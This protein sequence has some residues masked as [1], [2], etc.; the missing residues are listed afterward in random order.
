MLVAVGGGVAYSVVRAPVYKASVSLSFTDADEALDRLGVLVTQQLNPEKVAAANLST[1]TSPAV[2]RLSVDTLKKQEGIDIGLRPLRDSLSASVNPD[3]NLVEVEAEAGSTLTAT[4]IANTV[5][6]S[7]AIV[8]NDI[9]R[10]QFNDQAAALEDELAALQKSEARANSEPPSEREILLQ[11]Q[12][13]RL[14]GA[15]QIATPVGVVERAAGPSAPV[16][17]RPVRDSLL[18]GFLGL[19]LGVGAAITRE[20]LDR[21]LHSAAE[22]QTALALP[23]IGLVRDKA[24]GRAAFGV[25]GS[26]PMEERDIE[27]YRILRTN[28]AFLD[29][30]REPRS[31]VVTSGLPEEGKS[32]VAAS[33]AQTSA[34][35]GTRTLLLECD[36]RRPTLPGRLGLSR[37]PGLTDYLARRC[38]VHEILQQVTTAA[39]P[40]RAREV[41]TGVSH[42]LTCITAGSESPRPAEALGSERFKELLA[43]A[44]DTYELVVL[45]TSPLLSVV[46]TRELVPLVDA[47]L[48]CVRVSRTSRDQMVAAKATLE[49]F[50]ARPTGV[51]ITGVR[52]RDEPDYGYYSYN[53]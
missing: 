42:P 38:E 24:M 21:R 45:D 4:R 44:M 51:V 10:Q 20:S 3:N 14:K 19:L 48:L 27:A 28:L 43:Q 41:E 23:V 7:N 37:E 35:A 12:I 50:P 9:A 1:V 30:D 2:L 8:Q 31:V 52:Q 32:T 15:A 17:P 6:D 39:D 36:L 16:S 25:A 18:A 26:K 47:V 11:G 13:A 29:V 33:L 46:D 34:A 22:I 5:A 53:Y 49:L 40:Q